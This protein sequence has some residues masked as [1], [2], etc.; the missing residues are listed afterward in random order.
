MVESIENKIEEAQVKS[1]IALAKK[2]IFLLSLVIIL[3]FCILGA[4]AFIFLKTETSESQMVTKI[5]I[6]MR[7]SDQ[8]LK[9]YQ[10]LQQFKTELNT[11]LTKTVEVVEKL[12]LKSDTISSSIVELKDQIAAFAAANALKSTPKNKHQKKK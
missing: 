9:S 4:L 5:N 12:Q 10:E 8:S 3:L 7:K 6:L 2:Q 1:V 11:G